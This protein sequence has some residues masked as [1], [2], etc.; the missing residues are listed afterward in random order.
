MEEIDFSAA[1]RGRGRVAGPGR[2]PPKIGIGGFVVKNRNRIAQSVD[3]E[4]QDEIEDKSS[5]ANK[6]TKRRPR[7][8]RRHQLE[9]AYPIN[10]QTAFWGTSGVDGKMVVEMQIDEPT[11]EETSQ[12]MQ[13]NKKD[14]KVYELSDHA[15]E[16][17]RSQQE[18][19]MIGDFIGDNL[20]DI[21][22]DSFDFSDLLGDDE[23]DLLEF[24]AGGMF[25]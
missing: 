20:E 5:G 2:R 13:Q 8:P 1:G 11:L 9:D 17:L 7:K 19:D 6:S 22:M 3:D 23:D 24:G 21:D 10:I 14:D 15:S 4:P 25:V 16:A 18:Q 12:I